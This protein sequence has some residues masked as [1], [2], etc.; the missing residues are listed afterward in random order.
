MRKFNINKVK[1]NKVFLIESDIVLFSRLYT[2]KNTGKMPVQ[3]T[4][5][6]K[7]LRNQLN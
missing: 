5:S 1:F 4:F 3:G 7:F 2:K 6:I